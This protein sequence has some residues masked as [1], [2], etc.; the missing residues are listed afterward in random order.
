MILKF[1]EVIPFVTNLD[2]K[3]LNEIINYIKDILMIHV[4]QI[5]E[6]LQN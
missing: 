3:I 5:V 4:N 1:T 2:P 6:I